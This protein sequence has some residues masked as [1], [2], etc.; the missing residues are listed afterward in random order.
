MFAVNEDFSALQKA[1]LTT[2]LK[3]TDAATQA[4][5][6]WFELTMKT[7]KA[8]V[9]EALDQARALAAAKDVQELASLQTSFFASQRRE[10][11]RLCPCRLRLG[12]RYPQPD[13]QAGR[14]SDRRS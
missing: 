12:E 7:T 14:R 1:Q 11:H 10:G 4:A 2:L 5:E 3:Y 9:A 8:G 6:Q 13:H